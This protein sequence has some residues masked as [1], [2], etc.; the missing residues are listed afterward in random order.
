[1]LVD[2][3]TLDIIL[4]TANYLSLSFSAVV[5]PFEYLSAPLLY[6]ASLYE[7]V[8]DALDQSR[9]HVIALAASQ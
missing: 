6:S 1:M 8:N 5:I 7:N 4:Y 3:F 9:G 2:L